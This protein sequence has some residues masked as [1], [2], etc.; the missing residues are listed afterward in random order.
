MTEWDKKSAETA[1]QIGQGLI[2]FVEKT[3]FGT[4]QY[5]AVSDYLYLKQSEQSLKQLQENALTKDEGSE[6]KIYWETQARIREQKIALLE[7]QIYQNQSR[8]RGYDSA[9]THIGIGFE[10]NLV[11]VAYREAEQLFANDKQQQRFYVSDL[12]ERFFDK[13]QDTVNGKRD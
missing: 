12:Y 3:E 2:E 10:H 6:G 7:L 5:Q 1:E 9:Y 13:A 11:S 4:P 8:I